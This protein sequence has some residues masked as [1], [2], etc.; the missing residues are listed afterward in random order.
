MSKK[1]QNAWALLDAIGEADEKFVADAGRVKRAKRRNFW[2]YGVLAAC[3]ALALTV[4]VMAVLLTGE[5]GGTLLPEGD[6]DGSHVLDA[7]QGGDASGGESA[8]GDDSMEPVTS[9]P[10]T[11]EPETSEPETSH[12]G[13]SEYPND[14]PVPPPVFAS[15]PNLMEGL[16]PAKVEK[17]KADREFLLEQLRFSLALLGQAAKEEKAEGN[18]LLL[19]PL[20]AQ[21]ALSMTAN[22]ARG[23]TRE[24]MRSLL[25]GNLS[26]QKLNGYLHTLMERLEEQGE[27]Y[28][29]HIANAMWYN[30]GLQVYKEFLQTNADY[31]GAAAYQM[32]FDDAAKKAINRWVSE[33]TD[34]L[35]REAIDEIDPEMAMYLLNTIL[36]DGEWLSI[37][38]E[39]DVWERNFTTYNGETQKVPCMYSYE[40]TY[41]DDGKAT[42]FAKPYKGG[43][44]A[45]VALLPNEGVDVYDYVAGLTPEGLLH[46]LQNGKNEKVRTSLPK[47]SFAYEADLKKTLSALGMESAFQEGVADFSGMVTGFDGNGHLESVNQKTVISVGELGTKAAAVTTVV[48]APDASEEHWVL[49]D[50]PF[51]YLIVDRETSL[52]LFMGI[53][54]EIG[55]EVPEGEAP[56]IDVVDDKPYEPEPPSYEGKDFTGLTVRLKEEFVTPRTEVLYFLLENGS[57]TEYEY[58]GG[59]ILLQK[60][61]ENGWETLERLNDVSSGKG[62]APAG[63]TEQLSINVKIIYGITFAAEETYRMVFPGMEGLVCEFTVTG[64]GAPDASELRIHVEESVRTDAPNVF[65][66]MTNNSAFIFTYSYKDILLAQK[67]KDGWATFSPIDPD[68][69]EISLNPGYLQLGMILPEWYGIEFE[70][71]ATYRIIFAN[72]PGFYGEFTVQ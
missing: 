26:I 68:E 36:F 41:Y 67:T 28:K 5:S 10:G 8:P 17:Q 35:I 31:Y 4:P 60:K 6:G 46:T 32:P 33:Q 54:T 70:S 39:Q 3:L 15:A 63:K 29:L 1:K 55:G 45:F 11:S 64:I 69:R 14:P 13:T 16:V 7:S 47:F 30:E 38:Y 23:Q 18:S 24:E 20:S 2:R 52:P 21:I 22:G 50:R 40:G 66:E 44:Y 25:A 27:G 58:L 48:E 56:V 61:T 62:W 71:G 43:K 37:Y 34:G 59:A 65:F 51:V 57:E 53:Q 72:L 9:E 42:G 49:L 12:P 19:S